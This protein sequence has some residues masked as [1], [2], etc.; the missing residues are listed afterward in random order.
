MGVLIGPL[1][2]IADRFRDF[3]QTRRRV[4]VLV[5]RAF[6]QGG[7]DP[8]YFVKVTN[9]SPTREAEITHVWFESNPRVDMLMPERPLPARLRPYETWEGW[10]PA[11]RLAHASNVE[12]LGRVLVTG[13]SRRKGGKAVKSRPNKDVPPVGFVAGAGSD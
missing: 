1:L 7:S 11:A 4:R 9:V 3:Q 2:W 5:H 13:R 6:F 10:V 12:R 8:F